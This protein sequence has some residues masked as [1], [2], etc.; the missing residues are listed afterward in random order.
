MVLLY[1]HWLVTET[2]LMALVDIVMSV[3]G[4][5]TT[6]AGPTDTSLSNTT[7]GYTSKN[8]H[9]LMLIWQRMLQKTK[10][11]ATNVFLPS[12][13]AW[14]GSA[15]PA[16]LSSSEEEDEAREWHSLLR[17]RAGPVKLSKYLQQREVNYV[18][19]R[20]VNWNEMMQAWLRPHTWWCC[21]HSWFADRRERVFA[22]GFLHDLWPQGLRLR[23]A[24]VL[25]E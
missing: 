2:T 21:P 9:Q 3:R 20:V 12:E 4:A 23:A 15:A 19:C 16:G 18:L 24:D 14:T 6:A 22:S 7:T 1:E 11:W 10:S 8:K 13:L 25:D 17:L 5:P